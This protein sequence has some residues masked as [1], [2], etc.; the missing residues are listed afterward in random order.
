[1]STSWAFQKSIIEAIVF[2]R[3]KPGAIKR[4][5]TAPPAQGNLPPDEDDPM[6]PDQH[7]GDLPP[8]DIP[9]CD[10]P[11]DPL[12]DDNQP[13]YNAGPDPDDNDDDDQGYIIPDDHGPPPDDDL[14][15][16]G[17]QDSGETHDPSTP[18]TPVS[19]P[20]VP[21]EEVAGPGRDDDPS[22][23]PD[24]TSAPTRVQ[25][26]Q[27]QISVDSTDALPK[28][29]SK[30]I[31]KKPK[32]QLPGHVQPISV[33]TVKPVEEQEEDDYHDPQ[34]SSSNDP[35]IPLPTITPTSFMPGDFSTMMMALL[36]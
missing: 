10:E 13:D 19:D 3:E 24:P 28:A 34:A 21:L 17:I 1:M 16:P 5:F 35:S 31:I 26:K 8:E 9:I 2:S 12:D 6:H 20:D 14:D 29:N 23:G 33:P 32:V 7:G 27:R 25:R 22:P 36:F 15:M 18:S 11:D 4:R 30:V